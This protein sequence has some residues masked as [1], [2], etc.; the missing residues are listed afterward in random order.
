MEKNK[1]Q[2]IVLDLD[3][4]LLNSE[5]KIDSKT[6]EALIHLQQAGKKVVLASGRPTP[7]IMKLADELELDRYNGYVLA[8]NGGR[9]M[10]HG[11]KEVVYNKTVPGQYIAEV[12]QT[13]TELEMGILT[14][15]EDEIIL[16]TDSNEYCE[17]ESRINGI[18]MR[19]VDNFV[20]YIDF[21]INKLLLP[22]EPAQVLKAQE[23]LRAKFE[24]ELGIFR[25]EPFFLEVVPQSVDKA[26][27]LERLL[28]HLGMSREEMIC[29]GDGFNDVSMIKFAG[30]GVAMANAQEEVKQA[31]DYIT[32]S[33]DEQGIVQVIENFIL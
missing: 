5:K 24:K 29:C 28:E 13:A 27:S 19:K 25:S 32:A 15:T 3:G 31:A 7:G 8:F 4:T 1:Y 30:L 6:K 9:I 21:P 11:T 33:N 26:Y 10:N 22:A 18:G 23:I 17:I 20:E 14:Y 12:Y 16:G 2:I